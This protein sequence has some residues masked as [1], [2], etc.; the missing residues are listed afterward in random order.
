MVVRP[1]TVIIACSFLMLVSCPIASVFRSALAGQ[2]LPYRNA[3]VS[4]LVSIATWITDRDRPDQILP[5]PPSPS[6]ANTMRAILT[7]SSSSTKTCGVNS[8]HT[9]TVSV[10]GGLRN[11]VLDRLGS[12]F[13]EYRKR[14]LTLISLLLKFEGYDWRRGLREYGRW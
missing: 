10:V 13:T 4:I 6:T 7:T 8:L 3:S 5:S 9:H 2:Y 1:G 14:T 12:A 11:P